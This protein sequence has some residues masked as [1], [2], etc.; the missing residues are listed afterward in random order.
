M[1]FTNEFIKQ[2]P[3]CIQSS[4]IAEIVYSHGQAQT[5]MY[6]CAGIGQI[7]GSAMMIE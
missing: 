3:Y 5:A 2:I 7:K 1:A 4:K 6:I